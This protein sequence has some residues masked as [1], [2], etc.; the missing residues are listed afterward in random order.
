MREITVRYRE[1][2]ESRK[3]QKIVASLN[4]NIQGIEDVTGGTPPVSCFTCG[5]G[6]LVS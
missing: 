4:R 6:K 3:T 2:R 5:A 1:N